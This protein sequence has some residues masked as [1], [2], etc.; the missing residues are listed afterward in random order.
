MGLRTRAALLLVITSFLVILL[1]STL[2]YFFARTSL[3]DETDNYLKS[4]VPNILAPG[5]GVFAPGSQGSSDSSSGPGLRL[6]PI[7]N[8]PA[9]NGESAQ[10]E[11]NLVSNQVSVLEEQGDWLFAIVYDSGFVYQ[12]P[13]RTKVPIDAEDL[14]LAQVG[15]SDRYRT[16]E[17]SS[18]RLRVLTAPQSGAALLVARNV[19]TIDDSLSAIF[20]RVIIFGLIIACVAAVAGW[21][22]S[23]WLTYALRRFIKAT[24]RIS[25]GQRSD[26]TV[27]IKES[28]QRHELN[29]LSRVFNSMAKSLQESR[30]LQ[31]QLVDEAG[32]E[33]RT[34]LTSIRLNIDLLLHKTEN[35][36]T[37][38]SVEEQQ[39]LLHSVSSEVETL[40]RLTNELLYISSFGSAT[41]EEPVE[42]GLDDITEF[43]NSVAKSRLG[44][45]LQRSY[46]NPERIIAKSKLLKRAVGNIVENAI[47]FSPPGCLIELKVRGRTLEVSDR[48]MGIPES[49]LESIFERFH[50]S[51][52]TGRYAGSGLGLAIV[53]KIVEYHNGRVWARN[54][55]G[56]GAVVGFEIEGL[57]DEEGNLEAD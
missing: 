33:I 36:R 25:G 43:V 47:K 54:R 32:H 4:Q 28:R 53:K 29:R 56:G 15:G 37:Q 2:G 34:P 39:E 8:P 5:L 48:G 11:F 1:S 17:I 35:G 22:A 31:K 6:P 52:T 41:P 42:L 3:F 16:A 45:S 26:F 44:Y 57:S 55:E 51:D 38:F 10:S 50:R 14:R 49:E 13:G 23:G 20:Q 46:E 40:E 24:E 9:S 30:K 21:L 7:P 19:N 12:Q 18:G 27:R